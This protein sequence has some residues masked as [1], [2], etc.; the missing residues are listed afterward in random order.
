M[1]TCLKC[2]AKIDPAFDACWQCGTSK[3]GKEDPTFVTADDTG[4]IDEIPLGTA[5]ELA[6][7]P[8]HADA[9]AHSPK[10]ELVPCYQAFSLIE[11]QFLTNELIDNGIDSVCDEQDMQD[12]LGGWSGN[13][14]VYCREGDLAKARAFLENYE[15]TKAKHDPLEP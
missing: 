3:D 2:G 11:A 1:W 12:V 5:P 9:V 7:D 14:R 13:P 15:K 6:V 4:P 8:T 10:S